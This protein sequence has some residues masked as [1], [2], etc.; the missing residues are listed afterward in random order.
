MRE[1][2]G[3][4]DSGAPSAEVDIAKGETAREGAAAGAAANEEFNKQLNEQFTEPQPGNAPYYP[5]PKDRG[6]QGGL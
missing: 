5:G 3:K 1:K 6:G 4:T 2:I